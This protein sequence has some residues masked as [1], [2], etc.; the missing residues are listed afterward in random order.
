[1]VCLHVDPVFRHCE[2]N[3]GNSICDFDES[4]KYIAR[5]HKQFILMYSWTSDKLAVYSHV[6]FNST[7]Q[8]HRHCKCP[9]KKHELCTHMTS[10]YKKKSVKVHEFTFFTYTTYLVQRKTW[11]IRNPAENPASVIILVKRRSHIASVCPPFVLSLPKRSAVIVPPP[12]AH[13]WAEH[14]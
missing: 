6:I 8:A 14:V 9:K 3:R 7:T 12:W 13:K 2:L 4:I 5:R 10:A 1:M 11:Q